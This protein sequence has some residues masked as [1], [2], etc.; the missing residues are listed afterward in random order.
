MRDEIGQA[1]ERHVG[2]SLFPEFLPVLATK[3]GDPS[4][5][6]RLVEWGEG[7][8]STDC[9][10]GLIL[11]V[12]LYGDRAR[13]EF[14][15]LL[16]NPWWEA[17]GGGTGSN[18]W[19][20][21]GARVLGLSMSEL[22]GDLVVRLNSDAVDAEEKRHCVAMFAALLQHWVD[23][24]W[25]GLRAAP[26]PTETCD[27]LYD[28][29][30]EWPTPHRDESLTGLARGVLDRDDHFLTDLYQL[31]DGLRVRAGYEMEMRTVAHR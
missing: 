16:W 4:W 15:R 23:R 6:G 29:L 3:T 13:A 26:D 28:L 31:S 19:A 27:E 22:Y 30:F 20:Y 11:G 1:R 12:A 9:N 2:A 24:P 8:A 21:A 18:R 10:G 25:L 17:S 5:L 14:T 7:E